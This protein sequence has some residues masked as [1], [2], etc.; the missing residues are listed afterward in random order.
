[1]WCSPRVCHIQTAMIN[2]NSLEYG[3][4]QPVM[5]KFV[6][7]ALK[8]YLIENNARFSV[9]LCIYLLNCKM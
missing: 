1:M 3:P 5:I 8:C 9:A 6:Q 2:M 4:F 7:L